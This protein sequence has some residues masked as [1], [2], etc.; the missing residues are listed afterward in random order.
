[1]IDDNGEW[2][3]E[4]AMRRV[5]EMLARA[6]QGKPRVEVNGAGTCAVCQSEYEISLRSL[7]MPYVLRC[8]FCGSTIEATRQPPPEKASN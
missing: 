3:R 2:A 4:V 1:M 6:N 8:P 7:Y 5:H